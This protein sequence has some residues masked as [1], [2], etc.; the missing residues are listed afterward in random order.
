MLIQTAVITF[1]IVQPG[2]ARRAN[3]SV[4][5]CH[6]QIVDMGQKSPISKFA[7]VQLLTESVHFILN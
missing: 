7:T 5:K 1:V 2:N 4:Q 3:E 6:V